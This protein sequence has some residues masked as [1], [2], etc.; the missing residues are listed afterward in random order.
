M[1]LQQRRER[2]GRVG[3]QPTAGEVEEPQLDARDER[4]HERRHAPQAQ[5]AAVHAQKLQ[6]ARPGDVALA[7]AECRGETVAV[8]GRQWHAWDLEAQQQRVVRHVRNQAAQQLGARSSP[9]RVVLKAR[10]D[11]LVEGEAHTE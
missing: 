8:H 6:L 9:R 11:L 5:S 1:A 2:L 3:T 10:G 4:G 7:A